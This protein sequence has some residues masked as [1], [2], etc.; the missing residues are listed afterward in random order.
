MGWK[1][2]AGVICAVGLA[3]PAVGQPEN[4]SKPPVLS[5]EAIAALPLEVR[6]PTLLMGQGRYLD[7]FEAI[8]AT[9]LD[10]VSDRLRASYRQHHPALDGFFYQDPTAPPLPEPDPA[11]LAAYDGAVAEDAIRAILDRARDRRVVIVNE[12]HDSPRDRAFVLALAE[13]LKPL[14]FTHFAAETFT[15]ISPEIAAREMGRLQRAGYPL[16]STGTYT[17]GPMFAYLVRRALKLGYSP[18]SYEEA[19]DANAAAPATVEQGIALREQAQAENLARAL[20]A[21]GPDAK[22]LIHVGYAHAAERPLPGADEWM[23]AR[24]ARLT[25]LD[26]LTIEQTEISEV[27]P[28]PQGRALHRALASRVGGRPAVFMKDGVP[29]ATGQLGQATDLQV[30]HPMV[31]AVEGRPDWLRDT[32][33]FAVAIPAGLLPAQGRRLVQ[34]F[35]AGEAEDAVPLDQALV[36]AGE[37]PPVLYVPEGAEI[38]WAVQD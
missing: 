7:A 31:V 15:N 5:D 3:A 19:W 27:A 24:L 14:G 37:E 25:D 4:A 17:A 38:R 10:K 9:G 36:T 20:A 29:I 34:A 2:L 23:A 28:R 16:R 30:V 8:E 33:R 32:G 22:F 21:A 13:A 35:I 11:A 12:A 6:F 18:V 1:S 26:P